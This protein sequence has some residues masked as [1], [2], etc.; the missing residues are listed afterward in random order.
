MG[1]KCSASSAGTWFWLNLEACTYSFIK[2]GV[3]L[4]M[5]FL[6]DYFRS[7]GGFIYTE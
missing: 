4:P 6:M 3:G 1:K 7:E 5:S 2:V